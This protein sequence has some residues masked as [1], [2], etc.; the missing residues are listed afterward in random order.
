MYQREVKQSPFKRVPILRDYVGIL[1][2]N[3]RT[4]LLEKS[5]VAIHIITKNA[6]CTDA[7][8]IQ[9]KKNKSKDAYQ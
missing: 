1:V 9:I 3:S 2:E 4:R 7:N 5:F 6:R 8:P